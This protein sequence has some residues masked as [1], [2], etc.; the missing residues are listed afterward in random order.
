M[1]IVKEAKVLGES[2]ARKH[3]NRLYIIQCI[4][5]VHDKK[6]PAVRKYYK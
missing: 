2:K 3:I 6:K 5:V 1:S 4:I